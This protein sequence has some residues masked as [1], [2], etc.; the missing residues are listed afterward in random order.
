[1]STLS[2][3]LSHTHQFDFTLFTKINSE[4][5]F[6]YFLP[7][8]LFRFVFFSM[9]KVLKVE[10]FLSLCIGDRWDLKIMIQRVYT[11]RTFPAIYIFS[12]CGLKVSMSVEHVRY[13]CQV[14]R[15]VQFV[16]WR[17]VHSKEKHQ[18]EWR[19]NVKS[20]PTTHWRCARIFVDFWQN[21]TH[22]YNKL[23]RNRK[24]RRIN[25]FRY[26]FHAVETMVFINN[27]EC[28]LHS[29]FNTY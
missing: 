10:T 19:P 6:I 13:E 29:Y 11:M 4:I 23:I 26:L 18:M 17:K 16:F 3:S 24:D 27:F 12:F 21:T 9:Y 25:S 7:F 28:L 22:T 5:V 20:V 15:Q 1:M 2:W 14:S 8:R